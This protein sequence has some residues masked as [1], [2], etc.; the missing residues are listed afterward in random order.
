LRALGLVVVAAAFLG[1]AAARAQVVKIGVY[2]EPEW[3]IC[4]LVDDGPGLLRAYVVVDPP[5]AMISLTF[6]APKPPCLD[7]VWLGDEHPYP[8]VIGDSQ[9]GISIALQGCRTATHVLTILYQVTGQTPPC[10]PYPILPDPT[11]GLVYANCGPQAQPLGGREATINS[12]PE[13]MCIVDPKPSPPSL[14]YPIDSGPAVPVVVELAWE[15][16]DPA[17][18]PLT[19]DVYLGTEHDA[20][21]VASGLTEPRFRTPIL[22]FGTLYYWRVAVNDNHE[23]TVL[24]NLWKFT[25]VNES[26][27]SQ[28][29]PRV[30]RGHCSIAVTDSTWVDVDVTEALL[31]IDEGGLEIVFPTHMLDLLDVVRG[32]LT[33]SWQSFAWTTSGNRVSIFAS[34]PV[35]F[36]AGTT[37]TFA[38]LL[39]RSRCCELDSAL[40]SAICPENVTGDLRA[41]YPACN[42]FGCYPPDGDATGDGRITPE[43]ARCALEG[44]IRGSDPPPAECGGGWDLRVDVDCNGVV[45]PDDAFCIF[46]AWLDGSCAFCASPAPSPGEP[47]AVWART[48]TGAD[49]SIRVIVS[50]AAPALDAV[51]FDVHYPGRDVVF[52]GAT[53]LAAGFEETR[54]ARVGEGRLRAGGFA[55]AGAGRA[56]DLVVLRFSMREGEA[57]TV[58]VDGF[59][60]DLDG[61]DPVVVSLSPQPAPSQGL[62]LHQNRPNPFNPYTELAYDLPAGPPRHVRL[63]VFAVDGKRVATVIDATRPPGPHTVRWDGRDADGKSVPSGVYFYVLEAGGQSR[64]RKMVLLR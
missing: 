55:R 47:A 56:G 31:E 30:P 43:D 19:Y 2:A 51:G 62:V 16:S 18:D 53:W 13:C 15:A 44:Y 35:G 12:T 38:R 52:E 37:G 29:T 42:D 39:F 26:S 57:G 9:N 1:A 60:D 40:A 59:V 33:E 36:A 14:V 4:N 58:R 48:E 7:G 41:F 54:V 63:S 8:L 10:C 49:G 61:A 28:L 6:S 27:T 32:A 45:T 23:N 21:L 50:A 20:P 5:T 22:A 11:L 25:T 17:G 24:G 3:E 34:D 46:H 64:T